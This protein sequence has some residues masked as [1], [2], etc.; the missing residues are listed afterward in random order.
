MAKEEYCIVKPW[1]FITQ[2]NKNLVHSRV[3]ELI[4]WITKCEHPVDIRAASVDIPSRYNRNI[5]AGRSLP[6]S[7]VAKSL[8]L[9]LLYNHFPEG[10]FWNMMICEDGNELLLQRQQ[11]RC[12]DNSIK[13]IQVLKQVFWQCIW[14]VIHILCS[15]LYVPLFS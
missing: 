14:N 11:K 1:N 6:K 10:T 12:F 9:N 15:I 2:P 3:K 5:Y 4:Y 7:G 8:H 13:R